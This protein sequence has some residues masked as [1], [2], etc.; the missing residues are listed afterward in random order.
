MGHAASGVVG[1]RNAAP[2]PSFC[3]CH[4]QRRDAVFEA[5]RAGVP[6]AR[7]PAALSTG[8]LSQLESDR[9]EPEAGTV[10]C[11][12]FRTSHSGVVWAERT[13]LLGACRGSAIF[14][15]PHGP[16]RWS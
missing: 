10:R 3:R 13:D 7:E 6:T 12:L 4:I 2:E 15:K 5:G 8:P 16:A 14:R 9:N 11:R 1:C